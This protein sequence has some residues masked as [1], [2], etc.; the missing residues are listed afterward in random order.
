[1]DFSDKAL[2]FKLGKFREA[3]LWVRM[4]S[5]SRGIY[6]AFAF[7]GSR[8]IRRFCGCLD[9][10]NTV[11]VRVEAS[12]TKEYMVLGEASLLACP[13]RLRTDLGRLGMAVNCLKFMEAF[14]VSSD[15][16]LVSYKL[17]RDLL[18]L[19]DS[20]VSPPSL[21]P[22]LFRFRFAALQGFAP[23]IHSCRL[24]GFTFC[25][26]SYLY[27]QTAEGGTLCAACV[28]KSRP[29][30]C[31]RLGPEALS[32]LQTVQT[33]QPRDWSS[34]DFNGE[35]RAQCAEVIDGFIQ[36]HVG[37]VWNGGYFRRV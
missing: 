30:P 29:G 24:C 27:F 2:I 32:A 26:S 22:S 13:N 5:P 3:D 16:A 17:V 6:T 12:R 19:L 8:S 21:L 4:L 20:E 37:L 1:M 33:Q 14:N 9:L 25:R 7:G 10:L 31:V 34:L 28:H 35:V 11:Q 15:S 23:H 36:Y 18:D